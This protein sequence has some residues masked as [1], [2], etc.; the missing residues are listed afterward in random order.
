[1]MV[2]DLTSHEIGLL[3]KIANNEAVPWGAWVGACMEV[4]VARGY[5]SSVWQITDKGREYLRG[6]GNGA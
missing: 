4:L 5:C 6:L 2:D 3:T 1:M